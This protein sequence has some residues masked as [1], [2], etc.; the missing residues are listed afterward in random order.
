MLKS[1]VIWESRQCVQES[2][3]V[4]CLTI[5]SVPMS[6]CCMLCFVSWDFL[7]QTSLHNSKID[8]C[9]RCFK[10]FDSHHLAMNFKHVPISKCFEKRQRTNGPHDIR[11]D[12]VHFWIL[13]AGTKATHR[14]MIRTIVWG[15]SW[16]RSLSDEVQRVFFLHLVLYC[17]RL[18]KPLQTRLTNKLKSSGFWYLTVE[19]KTR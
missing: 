10:M 19:I 14:K 13:F 16:T 2:N 15:L 9:L 4:K 11:S 8:H 12:E 3:A 7:H 18:L 17:S 6:A 5:H 1:R